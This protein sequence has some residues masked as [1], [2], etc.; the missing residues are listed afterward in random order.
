MRTSRLL[1]AIFALA[2]CAPAAIPA[3]A[4]T[5]VEVERGEVAAHRLVDP[6]PVR[7]VSGGGRLDSIPIR[8]VVGTDGHVVSAGIETNPRLGGRPFPPAVAAR[9]SEEARRWRF[10]PFTRGGAPV[11]VT[12]VE[13]VGL[14]PPEDR[15]ARHIPIPPFDA[16]FRIALTRTPCYGTCPSYTV[17]IAAD[18]AVLY[19]GEDYVFA[20]GRHR[21]RIDPAAVRR[22]HDLAR[23]A[24]FFSLR[25]SY[26]GGVTDNPTYTVTVEAG[27]RR[28]RIRDYA[29]EM[30]GMPSIVRELEDAIDEAA[31]TRRWIEGDETVVPELIAERFDFRSFDG[32]RMAAL[33]ARAGRTGLVVRLIEAGAPFS[34]AA[35]AGSFAEPPAALPEAARGG[36]SEIVRYLLSRRSAWSRA[37]LHAALD[38]AAA[39]GSLEG[40][41]LLAGRGAL[42]GIDRMH[43]TRLLRRAAGSGDPRLVAR[44][45]RLRPDVNWIGQYDGNDPILADAAQVDCPWN[46]TRPRCDPPRVVAMLLR[47][48]ANPRLA[49]PNSPSSPLLFVSDVRIARLLLAA[50]ADPNFAD[51]DGAPPLFSIYDEDVALAMLDAGADPRARRPADRKTVFGW[52]SYQQWPRVLA[53]LRA[54]GIRS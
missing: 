14:Y 18:G 29:G 26:A 17:E 36:H 16:G 43:A 3:P 28:K 21:A 2:A 27:G 49:N 15:P 48:G 12:F 38:G 35:P 53:R 9:A 4:P 31:G 22:L 46:R 6:R 41:D 30:A 11:A 45:L 40:F 54:Q 32:A 13:T 52:A 42:A 23:R 20:R 19:T 44:V 10:R 39:A 5:A 24:D 51:F 47:A 34:A 8:I 1:A 33:A 25:E 50:G 37:D 7:A